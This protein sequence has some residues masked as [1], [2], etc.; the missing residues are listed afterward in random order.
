M[1]SGYY[2]HARLKFFGEIFHKDS[3]RKGKL[4]F[5]GHG[6]AGNMRCAD[7]KQSHEFPAPR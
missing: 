7:D 1:S 3:D 2:Y 6:M 5:L 4:A